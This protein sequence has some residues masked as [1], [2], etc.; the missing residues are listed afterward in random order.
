MTVE[1][2]IAGVKP[3]A[4]AAIAAARERQAQLT[5]PAGSLG[6]LEELSVRLAGMHGGT[7]PA[8]YARRAL[9]VMA[10]DHG[11][12]AD[13]VSAYPS[14]VT[15]QMLRG[16]LGGTAAICAIARSCGVRI[17]VA[18]LGVK[19]HGI[20][21]PRLMMLNVGRGTQSIARGPAM[22]REQARRAL[23]RGAEAFERVAS[24]GVDLFAVGEMGIGNTTPA[25]ALTAAVTGRGEQDICGRGT[26][27]DDERLA[28]KR[29]IVA[30]A[31]ARVAPD[32]D[33]VTLLAELGGFEIGGM[34]GA[35]LA[36]ARAGIP[37]V[38][39]GFIATAAALVA[40]RL[41]PASTDWMI[42]AHRGAEPGHTHALAQLGLH[43]LLE[44]DLR[45]GE[46]TGAA[47][48]MPLVDAAARTLREMATFAEAGVSGAV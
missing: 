16:F 8:G 10:G 20:D 19:G 9:I 33:G 12:A 36:A 18:D 45:L 44:L 7:P 24:E 42:A 3:A 39:D 11:V 15:A 32:A 14:E 35:M 17:Y 43:P 48:A 22:L 4:A 41:V 1:T 37:V 25:S 2:L 29:E 38:L 46:G 26:G 6:A 21:D 47:L 23:E 34:A 30:R 40:Q 28:R 31:V 5:K 27:I 13:G